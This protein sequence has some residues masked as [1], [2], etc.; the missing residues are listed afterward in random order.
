MGN[1]IK[2]QD[3]I[4]ETNRY[5]YR[6]QQFETK[7]FFADSIYTGKIIIDEAE[8]D[9]TNLVDDTADF[10]NKSRPRSK[11]DKDKKR[12]T[13]NSASTL[14]EGQ[15]STLNAFRSG[16]FPIKATEDKGLKISTSKQMLE[17]LPIA[18]AQVKAGNTSVNLLNEIRQIIYFLSRAKE[19][20]K[21]LHYDI[22]NSIKLLNRMDTIYTN[23]ESSKTCDPHRLL[24]N[25]TDK[26]NLN[27]SGIYVAW[28]NLSIYHR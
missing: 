7:R 14:Y 18:L 16:I 1:K 15:E 11:E 24:L 23:S 12:K 13:L 6:F 5:V 26:I 4:Y 8:I 17:R 25:L 2:W 28:S 22:M 3:L 10:N 27:G 20:T 19:L 9:Q 21:K